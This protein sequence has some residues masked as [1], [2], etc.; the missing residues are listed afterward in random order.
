MDIKLYLQGIRSLNKEI[1]SKKRQRESL[2]YKVTGS[3]IH[4]KE[5]DVQTSI[6]ADPMGN[7][8]AAVADL[9]REINRAIEDLC[10]QQDQ[11]AKLIGTLSDPRQRAI[12][13]DYYLNAFTWDKVADLNGYETRQIYRMHGEALN[14]LRENATK[15]Q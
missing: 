11:A 14:E 12:L 2:Y 13:T 1:E 3:A 4:L 9:D 6:K 5:I 7:T 8:M 15:C 10:R